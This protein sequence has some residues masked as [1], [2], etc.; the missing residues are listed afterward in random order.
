MQRVFDYLAKQHPKEYANLVSC[1]HQLDSHPVWKK[2]AVE[3]DLKAATAVL[4]T[5]RDTGENMRRAFFRLRNEQIT[6]NSEKSDAKYTKERYNDNS[7]NGY[8]PI[9][10]PAA[11]LPKTDNNNVNTIN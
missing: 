8:Y 4:I 10:I 6:Q 1:K 11:F 7:W 5:G 9:F 2:P 3:I